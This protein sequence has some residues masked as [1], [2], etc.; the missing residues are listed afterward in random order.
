MNRVVARLSASYL[1]VFLVVLAA[2][3]V[4]AYLFL[5]RS[6]LETLEPLRAL[7]EGQAAYA[8]MMR[9][10]AAIIAAFD[11]PLVAIVGAAAYILARFSVRPLLVAREREERFAADAAHELRTPL[12]TIATVAQAALTGDA[13]AQS[14]AL[15]KIANVALD[16]SDLLADLM[17]LMRE[18][19][20]E[21]RLHE[22]V[23]VGALLTALV[24]EEQGQAAP[25]EI[26]LATP[27]EGAYVIGDARALRQLAR[28]LVVNAMQHA[29]SRV[30]LRVGVEGRSVVVSVEDDGAG[31]APADRERIFE[32][33]FK[34]RPDS[35]G[36]GL[37]LAIARHI[38]TRHG[39]TI[40]LEDR[41]RFV[42][43]LPR[44]PP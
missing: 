3:S 25:L 22:P 42:A 12:A 37:G 39:G 21:K 26:T 24:C 35:P 6:A 15:T 33:F 34:A 19:P 10:V 30:T 2:L 9:R 32:R 44:A 14:G 27:A 18:A 28:N 36:S 29:R 16:A 41:A 8:A 11:L 40:G 7:P 5:A 17:A 13:A 38:A 1:A 23:D 20:N 43:R 4:G 31:V